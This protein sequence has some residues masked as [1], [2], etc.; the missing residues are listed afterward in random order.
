MYERLGRQDR[1]TDVSLVATSVLQLKKKILYSR[2]RSD[3]S[4]S[5]QV[6]RKHTSLCMLEANMFITCCVHVEVRLL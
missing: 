3:C 1:G 4:S 5:S 6:L 2:P